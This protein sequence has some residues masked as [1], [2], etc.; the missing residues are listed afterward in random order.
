MSEIALLLTGLSSIVLS[1]V[2]VTFFDT[3][4]LTDDSLMRDITQMILQITALSID[5][6]MKPIHRG[7]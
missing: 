2:V 7:P 6:I 1:F 4:G 3:D 5:I